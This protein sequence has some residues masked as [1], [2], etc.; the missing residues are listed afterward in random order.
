MIIAVFN[1]LVN[2]IDE[3]SKGKAPEGLFFVEQKVLANLNTHFDKQMLIDKAGLFLYGCIFYKMLEAT[4]RL[5]D[6]A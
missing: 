6:L 4:L 1:A 2:F 3:D 5:F